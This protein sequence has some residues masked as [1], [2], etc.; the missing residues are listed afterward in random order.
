MRSRPARARSI[1][2]RPST[3]PGTS[4]VTSSV[5]R[6]VGK[7]VE[8]PEDFA[9][10]VEG[11]RGHN[12]AKGGVEAALWDLEAR[13][14]DKPL[15]KLL[16][17]S[18]EQI[19]CGVSIGIQPTIDRLLEVIQKEVDGRL[20]PHQDQDQTRLG[21]RGCAAG[22]SRLSKDSADVRCQFRIHARRY[23]PLP[24]DG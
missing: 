8:N 11:I 6:L 18:R 9:P 12:M 10:M 20:P 17:G 15:W 1:A 16:G 22:A 7:D 23:R 21:C 5:P 19:E 4:S 2:T 14:Q 3:P 13:R 24:A